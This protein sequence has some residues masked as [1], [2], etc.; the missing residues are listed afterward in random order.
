MSGFIENT[1]LK[2][3][4]LFTISEDYSRVKSFLGY[5]SKKTVFTNDG[6]YFS[7]RKSLRGSLLNENSFII[8][9]VTNSLFLKV[10][11]T[12]V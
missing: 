7:E 12:V 6:H 2:S 5:I 3:I 11:M 4:K 9:M 8:Q 1:R 10:F